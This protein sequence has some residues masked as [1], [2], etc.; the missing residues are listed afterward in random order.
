MARDW[1]L[2]FIALPVIF[3]LEML[4]G[5]WAWQKLRSL[6]TRNF[7]QTHRHTVYRQLLCF[8]PDVYLGGCQFYRP[9]TMQRSNLPLSYPMTARKFLEARSAECCGVPEASC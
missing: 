6:N 7:R 3:L 5:T 8:A 1:Q 2:M 9:I 4:F